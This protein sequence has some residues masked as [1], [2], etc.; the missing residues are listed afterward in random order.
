[1]R[2]CE[3]CDELNGAPSSWRPYP[4]LAPFGA[5]FFGVPPQPVKIRDQ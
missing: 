1:M 2:A 4:N 3:A 5:G